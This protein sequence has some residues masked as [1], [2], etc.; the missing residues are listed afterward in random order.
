KLVKDPTEEYQAA[1]KETIKKSTKIRKANQINTLTTMNQSAP[2]MNA[3]PKLHKSGTPMRPII[4]HKS[5]PSYKLSKYL[6][7]ILKDNLGLPNKNT[8]SSTTELIEKLK[9]SVITLDTKLVSFDIK[10]LYPSIPI[11]ETIDILFKI[12]T[13]KTR[14]REIAVEI[15]NALRTTLRRNYFKFNN[16]VYMQ[17]NGLGM[18]NPTSAILMEVFMQNLEE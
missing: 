3:L 13:E 12:L 4:N 10:N 14:N 16:N 9:D 18:G 5:A 6:K 7:T 15:T 8:I 2:P 1:I 17:T 11:T